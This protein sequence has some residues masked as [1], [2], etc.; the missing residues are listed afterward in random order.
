MIYMIEVIYSEVGGELTRLLVRLG[1][2]Y[3]VAKVLSLLIVSPKP[4]SMKEIKRLTGLSL[5]S[6]SLALKNLER[7]GVVSYVKRGRVKL[8]WAAKGLKHIVNMILGRLVSME[9]LRSVE[10]KSRD[11]L[12]KGYKHLSPLIED[13]KKIIEFIHG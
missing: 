2:T 4:L 12:V 8:F 3:S 1:Y 9:V 7:E 13:I 5:G 10:N 6:V 11:L